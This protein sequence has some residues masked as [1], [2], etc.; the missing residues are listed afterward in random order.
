MKQKIFFFQFAAKII[1]GEISTRRKFRV[2][3]FPGGENSRRW[4]FQAPKIP[5]GWNFGGWK[6][7]AAKIPGI[8]NSHGENSRGENPA[9][10]LKFAQMGHG[11]CVVRTRR[12]VYTCV[13]KDY[14]CTWPWSR[15]TVGR[16][17]KQ[18]LRS[19]WCNTFT[20]SIQTNQRVN[21]HVV[22]DEIISILLVILFYTIYSGISWISI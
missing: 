1:F 9:H 13:R 18:V 6:L 15:V 19:T 2:A 10:P 5:N 20:L 14:V 8:E 3:K 7:Q 11:W 4:K 21:W 17:P 22:L 12:I 16:L